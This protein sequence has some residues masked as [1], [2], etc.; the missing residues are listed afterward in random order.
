M[1]LLDIIAGRATPDRTPAADATTAPAGPPATAIVATV[2]TAGGLL[3]DDTPSRVAGV[4]IV[5]GADRDRGGSAACV[6]AGVAT[7]AVATAEAG[8][9]TERWRRFLDICERLGLHRDVV[10][11]EF[12]DDDRTDLLDTYADDDARLYRCAETLAGDGRLIASSTRVRQGE[13]FGE[14]S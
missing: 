1:S 10:A 11:D 6:V 8:C 13:W 9:Q 3:P 14:A 2:A 4:A 7:V 12:T 5:A